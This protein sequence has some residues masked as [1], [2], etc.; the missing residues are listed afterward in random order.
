[1]AKAK[2]AEVIFLYFIS[3]AFM[4]CGFCYNIKYDIGGESLICGIG[5]GVFLAIAS[6]AI[7]QMERNKK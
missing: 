1:M 5:S 4:L 6:F 7:N 2:L 3:L